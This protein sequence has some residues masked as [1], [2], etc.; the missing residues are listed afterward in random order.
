MLFGWAASIP[1]Y[2]LAGPSPLLEVFFGGQ[3]YCAMSTVLLTLLTLM[4]GF[5]F[6]PSYQAAI[7]LAS[8]NG[9]GKD[10]TQTY[11]AV[12]GT[13]NSA[14]ALGAM[15]GPIY[16]NAITQASNYTWTLT[17]LAGLALLALTILSIYLLT[18]KICKLPLKPENSEENT[19]MEQE[20][21]ISNNNTEKSITSDLSLDTAQS[22]STMEKIFLVESL[23]K[24]FGLG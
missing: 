22:T 2:L 14:I 4:E 10:S 5:L 15:V 7:N 13:L 16:G 12:T 11:A 20:D 6:L 9:H 3:R 23:R 8:A 19:K 1:L 24:F 18:M 17:S 21:T